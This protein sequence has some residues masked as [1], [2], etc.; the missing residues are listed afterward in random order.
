MNAQRRKYVA[1][2][3]VTI[4]IALYYSVAAMIF[5]DYNDLPFVA[6]M[7][8]FVVPSIIIIVMMVVVLLERF[9][10]IKKGEDNDLSKY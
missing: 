2:I 3:I 5:Y 10:E 6:K 7:V 9:K 1:P 8:L 4:F